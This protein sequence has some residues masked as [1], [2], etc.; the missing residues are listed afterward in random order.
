MHRQFTPRQHSFFF[1]KDRYDKKEISL[2]YCPKEEMLS[3]VYTKLLQGF[4]VHK[5]RDVIL[6]LRNV[7][8][9]RNKERQNTRESIVSSSNKDRV[10]RSV[11]DVN[12]NDGENYVN[13]KKVS[14]EM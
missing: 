3:E 12:N 9:L 7:S 13:N 14:R 6:G 5:F 8:T 4:L 11:L 10:E 1:V 2:E